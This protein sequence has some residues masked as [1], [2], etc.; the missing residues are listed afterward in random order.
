LRKL[1]TDYSVKKTKILASVYDFWKKGNYWISQNQPI[2]VDLT[3]RI[4][5]SSKTPFEVQCETDSR[6]FL[7]LGISEEALK[8]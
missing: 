4:Q 7:N 5:K 1:N 6:T 2:K 8:R 3:R